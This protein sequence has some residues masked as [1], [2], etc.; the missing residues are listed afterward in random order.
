MAAI[1]FCARPP[2]LQR[3]LLLLVAALCSSAAL[4]SCAAD[5]S[6]APGFV[7]YYTLLGLMP[8]FYMRSNAPPPSVLP[9]PSAQQVKSAWRATSLAV[10]P[11]KN[12]DVDPAVSAAKFIQLTEAKETLLDTHRKRV[13]YDEL[14][15][16]FL[17]Q[18]LSQWKSEQARRRASGERLSASEAHALVFTGRFQPP[19][20]DVDKLKTRAKWRAF[21][22][23]QEEGTDTQQ[24]SYRT[25]YRSRKH[26]FREGC[27][28]KI[29]ITWYPPVSPEKQALA[30]E[31][32]VND[33]IRLAFRQE[34]P[35]LEGLPSASFNLLLVG[36]MVGG[37]MLRLGE[38]PLLLGIVVFMGV[39]TAGIISSA[40]D[41]M[42]R[43]HF[44]VPL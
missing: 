4:L 1:L 34:H 19:P 3:T 35:W 41:K 22:R 17:A 25:S 23:E 27:K 32:C 2:L 20:V 42:I 43:R 16:Q 39:G 33:E 11:D 7:D 24:R 8:A 14:F 26:R 40:L 21:F 12:P 13:E 18:R 44:D 31:M 28:G 5:P 37:A 30:E 10:H 36:A 29:P 9:A 38:K 6:G 15:R